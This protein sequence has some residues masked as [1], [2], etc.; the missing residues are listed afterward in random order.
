MISSGLNAWIP[1][2]TNVILPVGNTKFAFVKVSPGYE[3]TMN[4]M[5]V[6]GKLLISDNLRVTSGITQLP[7]PMRF[8]TEFIN[9]PNGFLLRFLRTG[10][11]TDTA[12]T[13]D[14][15]FAYSYQTI[16]GIELPTQI[17]VTPPTNQAWRYSLSDCRVVKGK[18]IT[19][20][21]EPPN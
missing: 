18:T 14:A 19:I 6:S 9:G 12:T 3:L 4:G 2:S 10:D 17:T 16:E 15:T 21:V 13:H 5:G 20:Q 1:S 7:Q 8:E 11:T